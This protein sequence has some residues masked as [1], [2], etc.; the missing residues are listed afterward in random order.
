[1][2]VCNLGGRTA[3]ILPRLGDPFDAAAAI[4]FLASSASGWITGQTIPV[5]GGYSINW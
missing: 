4:L 1:M 3:L 2:N 5:S